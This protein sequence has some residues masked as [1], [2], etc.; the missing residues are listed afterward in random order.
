MATGKPWRPLKVRAGREA[1]GP[2]KGPPSVGHRLLTA[3][4]APEGILKPRNPAI[5]PQRRCSSFGNL[6]FFCFDGL[7]SGK[8]PCLPLPLR[9][10]ISIFSLFACF[11]QPRFTFQLASFH[12]V[13]FPNIFDFSP[14]Q[15]IIRSLRRSI[16]LSLSPQPCAWARAPGGTE[17][18]RSIEKVVG[19]STSRWSVGVH[20]RMS[21]GCTH[22]PCRAD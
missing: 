12:F 22:Y 11:N 14:T 18:R 9:I 4:F 8:A 7:I 1:G 16:N 3:K 20:A 19:G 13:H 2:P 6:F 21:T 5:P 15:S 10:R 17:R